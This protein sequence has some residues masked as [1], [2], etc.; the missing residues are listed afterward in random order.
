MSNQLHAA[1]IEDSCHNR[2]LQL[3]IP[4][5]PPVGARPSCKIL[6]SQLAILQA[7]YDISKSDSLVC[8]GHPEHP[9]SV[10]PAALTG[11]G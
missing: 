8:A 1:E 5:H 4:D 6:V 3:D 11:S 10:A 2:S 9:Q 7:V